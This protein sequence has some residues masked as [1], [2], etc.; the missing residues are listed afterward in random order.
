MKTKKYHSPVNKRIKEITELLKPHNIDFLQFLKQ[1]KNYAKHNKGVLGESFLKSHKTTN[2]H[3]LKQ[4]LYQSVVKEY[5]KKNR[6][7]FFLSPNLSARY[8]IVCLQDTIRADRLLEAFM[9]AFIEGEPAL[10]P[11]INVVSNYHNKRV[12][13]K[14]NNL[15]ASRR[16]RM[17]KIIKYYNIPSEWW[18]RYTDLKSDHLE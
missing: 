6:Y 4:N 9:S 12:F 10:D 5:F 11:F 3:R 1:L 18:L 2:R 8:R 7:C 13:K 14:R 16:E 15:L 17:K